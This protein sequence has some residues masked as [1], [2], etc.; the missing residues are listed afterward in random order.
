MI[1]IWTVFSAVMPAYLLVACGAW[2]RRAEW[3]THEADESLLRVVVNVLTPCLIL[4]NVMS[5]EALRR[6]GN[7]VLAPLMGFAGVAVGLWVAGWV[8]RWAG[9]GTE[10]ERRTFVA[11]TG[12]QNYG[13]APLP[14][15]TVLF[16]RETTGVLFLHNLGVDVALWTLGLVAFGHAGWR[17]WRKLLNPPLMAVLGG[18]VLNWAGFRF[19]GFVGSAVHML[20]V[21]CFP[22]GLVL[23]GA[24]LSEVTPRL[25]EPG[26]ARLMLA[27]CVARCG[28]AP[29]VMLLL[30]R[31]MPASVELKR[32][33]VVEAAMPAAVFPIVMARH[34][35]GDVPTSVRVVVATS[36]LGFLTIPLWVRLGLWLVPGA[37]G[38]PMAPGIP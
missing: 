11:T 19:P 8:A 6:P 34:Y 20:G 25:R 32:V 15:I 24:T 5:N 17:A 38:V 7:V 13:Y 4:D 1:D 29:A 37:S 16:P 3:L 35:G 31:W 27:S 22:L 10:A 36:A 14:L 18:V 9:A 12:F 30:A 23:I 2:L 28:V 26:G 33:L 21:S